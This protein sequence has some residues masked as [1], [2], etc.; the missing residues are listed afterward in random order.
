MLRLRAASA[1]AGAT[2]EILRAE[3]V[4][5][6]RAERRDG[7][8]RDVAERPRDGAGWAEIDADGLEGGRGDVATWLSGLARGGKPI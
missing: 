8:G 3:L 5:G 6:P 1:Q 2:V 4:A 7:R